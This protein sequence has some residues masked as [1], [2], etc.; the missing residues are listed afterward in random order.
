M[1]VRG[2]SHTQAPSFHLGN[3]DVCRRPEM[4]LTDSPFGSDGTCAQNVN[5]SVQGSGI[6]GSVSGVQ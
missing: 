3:E 1:D 2:I 6:T 4:C 5:L